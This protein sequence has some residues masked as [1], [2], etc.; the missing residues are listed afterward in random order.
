LVST[1]S[2]FKGVL[3]AGLALIIVL[4]IG[5]VAAIDFYP[6]TIG[7]K[8]QAHLGD[9]DFT[10]DM[11]GWKQFGK[12]FIAWQDSAV[13]KNEIAPSLHIVCNK[14]FPAAHIDYYISRVS[15]NAV[16]GVGNM[17]DLHQFV[18]LN[19]YQPSFQK[20]QDALCIIPSNYYANVQNS[21]GIYFDSIQP[22]HVFSC[23]RSNNVVRYFSVYLLKG[24][25][26][27]DEAQ[28][29]KVQ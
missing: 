28:M 19:K 21:Y 8:E 16:I 10:L 25:K 27:N 18:W 7:N 2:A 20:G 12:D 15:N 17:N 11:Y 24:Y 23:I 22:L 26:A 13:A 14:W 6:G 29:Y 4:L 5:G 9:G 1:K 3:K